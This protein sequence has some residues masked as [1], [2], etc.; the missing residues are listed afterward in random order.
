[1]QNLLQRL[2]SVEKKIK[3]NKKYKCSLRG[4]ILG[5]VGYETAICY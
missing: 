2:T 5:Q 1:M 3:P 4:Y